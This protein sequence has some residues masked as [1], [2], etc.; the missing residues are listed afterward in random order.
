MI[1]NLTDN[2]MFLSAYLHS[3]YLIGLFRNI[4]HQKV[5]YVHPQTFESKTALAI[6]LQGS[7]NPQQ[8]KFC[9]DWE[10]LEFLT[11]IVTLN[12]YFHNTKN[13]NNNKNVCMMQAKLYLY[14]IWLFYIYFFILYLL[15]T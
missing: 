1:L 3:A 13:N 4:H 12:I 14:F 9:V 5:L 2:F 10:N 6:L 8:Q 11:T 7:L 15:S